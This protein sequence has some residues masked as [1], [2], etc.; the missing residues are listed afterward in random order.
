MSIFGGHFWFL[1]LFLTE[2]QKLPIENNGKI[3]DSG[4]I[5]TIFTVSPKNF[6]FQL[7][8]EQLRSAPQ[9]RSK[10]FQKRNYTR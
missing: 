9:I 4:F 7:L 2:L 10:Y 6:F 3:Y 1:L 8:R 5:A